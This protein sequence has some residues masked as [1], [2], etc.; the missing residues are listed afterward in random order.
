VT[1]IAVSLVLRSTV[2]VRLP[3]GALLSSRRA[4]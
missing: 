4:F 1:E 2:P 3:I